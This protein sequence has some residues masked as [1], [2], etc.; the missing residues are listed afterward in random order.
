M[1]IPLATWPLDLPEIFLV[2]GFSQY[3]QSNVLVDES[4]NSS[5]Q[6]RRRV[7]FTARSV[8]STGQLVL[9]PSEYEIFI[10]FVQNTLS[11]GIHRFTFKNPTKPS[12]DVVVRFDSSEDSPMYTTQRDNQTLDWIVNLNLEML[13]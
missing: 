10:M 8:F 12:E 7:L 13:P 1:A 5:D 2:D 9:S 11:D 6:S 3:T 4:K